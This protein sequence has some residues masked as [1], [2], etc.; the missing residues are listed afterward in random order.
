MPTGIRIARLDQCRAVHV[1]MK[2]YE[3]GGTRRR[4]PP[5][6][7]LPH[8][9]DA[10]PSWQA[11]VEVEKGGGGACHEGLSDSRRE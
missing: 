5:Q 6:S 11:D 1:G 4:L 8:S 3:T 2:Y 10:C 9:A 7:P